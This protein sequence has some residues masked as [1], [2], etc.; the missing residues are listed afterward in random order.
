MLPP[1]LGVCRSLVKSPG[2]LA[3]GGGGGGGAFDGSTLDGSTALNIRVNS[4]T[5]CEGG[6][7][8]GFVIGFI[9]AGVCCISGD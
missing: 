5:C 4:P 8:I 2:A 6:G 3:A 1:K 7:A 9:G